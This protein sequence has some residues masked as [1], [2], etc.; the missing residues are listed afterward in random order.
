MK[1]GRRNADAIPCKLSLSLTRATIK[2]LKVAMKKRWKREELV[3]RYKTKVIAIKY[4]RAK[5][6]ICLFSKEIKNHESNIG[7]KMDPD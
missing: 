2:K 4:Q 3:K 7:K 1:K 6:R 5:K